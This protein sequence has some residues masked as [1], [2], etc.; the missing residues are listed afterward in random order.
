MRY[1]TQTSLPG[2][3]FPSPAKISAKRSS[4]CVEKGGGGLIGL[5]IIVF[6]FISLKNMH[7]LFPNCSPLLNSV[8][9]KGLQLV[10]EIGTIVDHQY[11][12]HKRLHRENTKPI[13]GD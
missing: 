7:I 2:N 6:Q 8:S 12:Q 11:D 10:A 4:S 13:L 3:R 9:T 1:N 5:S